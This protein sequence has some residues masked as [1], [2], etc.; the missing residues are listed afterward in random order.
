MLLHNEPLSK[1]TSWRVGGPA[2]N[3]FIAD[4][5][6]NLVNFLKTLPES[7]NILWLGLGSNVLIRDGGYNGTVIITQGSFLNTIEKLEDNIIKISAGAACGTVARTC[8]RLGLMGIEF[9][10]GVPG[11]MGGA[12]AMNAGAHGGETWNYVE[13]CEVINRRGEIKIRPA[14]DYKVSYRQVICPDNQEWFLAGYLK[15]IPGNKEESLAKIKDLL[16]HRTNTQPINLPNCGSVFRNPPNNFAAKLIES[17]NLKGFKIGGAEVSQK[18][19]N[20]IIN[21]GHATAHDIEALIQHIAD[22]VKKQHDIELIR[23]VHIIGDSLEN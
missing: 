7:E 6:N 13:Q 15:L 22:A 14:A 1:Y 20:F 17:C 10:A 16:A 19:A 4:D 23:E 18:H 5:L 2:K 9:L 11:T 3:V 12:L 21:T 8:A